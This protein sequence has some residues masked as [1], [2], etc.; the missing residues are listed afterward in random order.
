MQ[1][2]KTVTYPFEKNEFEIRIYYAAENITV[3]AFLNGRPANGYR[4]QIKIPKKCDPA[5]VLKKY[6]VPELIEACKSHIKD[7]QWAKVS[8]IIQDCSVD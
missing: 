3:L 4:Y 2:F 8:K 7:N 5:K 6:P 1:L